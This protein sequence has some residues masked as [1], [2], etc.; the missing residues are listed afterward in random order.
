MRRSLL[1][2]P[3]LA[4]ALAGCDAFT[5]QYPQTS[6]YLGVEVVS[7]VAT[8]KTAT[9]HLMSMATGQD[10]SSIRAKDEGRYCVSR[11][12]EPIKKP[13]VYCYRTLGQVTCY[14]EPDPHGDNAQPI[15][16]E[17]YEKA[18]ARQQQQQQRQQQR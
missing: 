17:P 8:G 14:K 15:G 13:D 16:L 18:A 6:G 12:G 5:E 11:L 4:L 9:D 1:L 10:C 7:L 2:V 3:A